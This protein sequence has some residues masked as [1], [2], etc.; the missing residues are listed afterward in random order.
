MINEHDIDGMLE[1]HN[2]RRGDLFKIVDDS[3]QVPPAHPP[4]TL[5]AIFKFRHIDGMYSYCIDPAGEVVHFA[6][7]TKV[8]KVGESARL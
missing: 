8:V 1:L 3:I 7:W 4:F 6:A 2:L 5:D